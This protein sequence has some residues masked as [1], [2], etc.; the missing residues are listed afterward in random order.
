LRDHGEWYRIRPELT[1]FIA[2]DP[3]MMLA[4]HHY[5]RVQ[6]AR[7]AIQKYMDKE[8]ERKAYETLANIDMRA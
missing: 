4:R 6:L 3:A 8:N 1:D 2:N 7:T 5:K